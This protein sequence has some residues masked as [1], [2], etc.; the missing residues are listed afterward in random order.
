MSDFQRF[1][2]LCAGRSGQLLNYS[3]LASDCGISQPSAKAWTSILKA[4]FLLETLPPWS[5]NIRKRLVKSPKM[6]L[7]DSGLLCWLLGIRNSEQLL[8]HPLRGAIF[9]SWAFAEAL[10]AQTLSAKRVP[11]SHY[12]DQSGLKVDLVIEFA[13]RAEL[14]EFK[15]SRTFHRNMLAPLQ[16]TASLWPDDVACGKTVFY[17]GD[18][19]QQRHQAGILPWHQIDRWVAAL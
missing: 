4:S 1:L 2:G 16:K 8:T 7:I 11:M 14:V 6:Y 18:H 19:A 12:R 5:G 10:K 9:E 15:S 3:A 13:A 17:G